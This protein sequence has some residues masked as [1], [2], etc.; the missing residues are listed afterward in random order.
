[1]SSKTLEPEFVTRDVV[2]RGATY[3]LK[4][5]SASKYDELV[6]Q[7]TDGNDETDGVI[8]NRLMINACLIAPEITPEDL[9]AK[10]YKLIR[11]LGRVVNE[12]HYGEEPT[13][14]ND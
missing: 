14:K 13:A 12:L 6:K 5:L 8:L 9:A 7:A 3:S 11:E 2:F 10:P 1:M 4:E